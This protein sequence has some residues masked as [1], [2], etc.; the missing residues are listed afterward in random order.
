MR[1]DYNTLHKRMKYQIDMY[2][3]N[4]RKEITLEA[5]A[6]LLQNI[7]YGNRFFPIYAFC[8]LGGVDSTG[9]PTLFN[10]DAIGSYQKVRGTAVGSGSDLALSILDSLILRHHRM[11]QGHSNTTTTTTSSTST[12]AHPV[13]AGPVGAGE[14]SVDQGI[15]YAHQI[16]ASVSERDI[17]TGDAVEIYVVSKDG[18]QKILRPLKMD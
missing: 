2:K 10:Y 16:F 15:E 13:G 4:N 17:Y 9:T 5:A 12:E 11:P 7:L 6:Q 14:L 3:Y 1:A 8:I 18:V